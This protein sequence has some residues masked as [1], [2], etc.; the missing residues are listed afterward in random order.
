MGLV[1]K[2]A[3]GLGLLYNFFF[4]LDRK[5]R[6]RT[7]LPV[8]LVSVGNIAMGGRA[9]TPFV[10]FLCS[11]LKSKGWEPVVLTRGYKRRSKDPIWLLPQPEPRVPLLYNTRRRTSQPLDLRSVESSGDEAMEIALR[12]QVP[13]LIGSK[14]VKNAQLY[15]SEA[16]FRM[17]NL[18]FVLDD[19]F[20][21]WSLLRD[22]DLVIVAPEDFKAQIFPA[23]PL[24][25]SVEGLKRAD[26]VLTLGV[27]LF[28]E[29]RLPSSWTSGLDIPSHLVLLSGRAPD[30][31]YKPQLQRLLG[32]DIYLEECTLRDHASRGEMTETI[33]RFPKGTHFLIGTK[34][35]VKLCDLLELAQGVD[36]FSWESGHHFHVLGLDIKLKE[37]AL[38]VNEIVKKLEHFA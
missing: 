33:L 14:R 18:V 2:V 13:V 4:Q 10:I 17:R 11:K 26:R 27:D 9:K 38:V 21:H 36:T 30:P 12:A 15:L 24:R 7:R 37:E 34:E 22:Y 16:S 32:K 31:Y 29:T 25:E 23:G 35:A 5:T 20:Q 19:G 3:S 28:K 8:P 6:G 1:D